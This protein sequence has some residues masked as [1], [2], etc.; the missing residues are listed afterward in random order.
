MSELLLGE[1]LRLLDVVIVVSAMLVAGTSFFTFLWWRVQCH[2]DSTKKR[3]RNDHLQVDSTTL[4][5]HVPHVL[6]H[7]I[8]KG[9]NNI[10]IKA[11]ETLQALD[12]EQLNLR[13]KQNH[14]VTKCFELIQHSH[15]ILG[16]LDLKR[17]NFQVEALLLKDL[18]QRIIIDLVPYAKAAGVTIR[19]ELEDVDP[20]F[21]NR[22]FAMQVI[23]NV[24]HN[25]IKYSPSGSVVDIK[26]ELK[27]NYS[28]Y[29]RTVSIQVKDRG[30]GLAAKDKQRVFE[31]LVRGDGTIERGSGL[32]LS[33]A[34]QMALLHDGDVR[35]I[36]S[37]A[38]HG[39]T[40]EVIFPY[41]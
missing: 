1:G 16:L 23:T 18:I 6:A 8:E 30:R 26:L 10:C 13:D 19:P 25:A 28:G 32:G 17:T 36:E 37:E 27:A 11:E 35:L 38:N 4:T 41:K 34:R 31:F 21:L 9:L 5:S 22:H 14:I 3:G 24:V 2:A 29:L 40:F 39:S 15:N 20:I 7:E 33:Y 12:F